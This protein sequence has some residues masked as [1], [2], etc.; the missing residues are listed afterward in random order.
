VIM[1]F[2]F[3]ADASLPV[4]RQ[5]ASDR[6]FPDSSVTSPSSLEEFFFP[7][8]FWPSWAGGLSEAFL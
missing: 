4:R 5:A 8:V 6:L 3:F 1:R 2:F 7:M